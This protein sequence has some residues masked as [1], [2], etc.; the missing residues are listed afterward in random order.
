[1]DPFLD[2]LYRPVG[3]LLRLAQHADPQR[4]A[5]TLA[6]TLAEFGGMNVRLYLLDYQHSTLRSTSAELPETMSIDG[7][8]A[9]RAFTTGQ[10]QAVPRD[11]RWEVW[12]PVAERTQR[13][14]VLGVTLPAWEAPIEQLCVELG[15]AAGHLIASATS[16]T[17]RWVKARRSK[18]MALAAE[19]QWSML[20]PLVFTVGRTTVAGL[21]EPAYDVAGDCFDYSLN[22]DIVDVVVF[23]AMGH[24]LTSSVLASLAL[25]TYRH[26]RRRQRSPEL[27]STLRE[28]DAVIA[29]YARGDSFVTA[30]A[31][32]VDI[33]TGRLTWATA[34]H[35]EPLHVRGGHTLAPKNVQPSPPLGLMEW[36]GTDHAPP[37]TSVYL[38]PGDG[39]L[40]YTDGVVEARA[41]AGE[42]FGEDRLRDFLER[43][44]GSGREPAEALRHLIRSV[45]DYIAPAHLRDDA[46]TVFLQ[47]DGA[48]PPRR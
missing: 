28:V 2:A 30:I 43:A 21:L 31:A 11:E 17:D 9:G 13:I 16:Y 23:D 1:M 3:R 38:E 15:I 25:S 42:P 27:R 29:D 24:G 46:T 22:D 32:S 44:S 40:F 20:P 19:I 4:V 6:M 36:A 7:T 33:T 37:L 8:V 45:V 26:S 12:V 35:P 18:P 5:D 10:S 41:A 48:A 47:W 39:L 14:G 34:G